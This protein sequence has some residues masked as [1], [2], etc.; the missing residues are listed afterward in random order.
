MDVLP[1]RPLTAAPAGDAP[2][3]AGP[4]LPAPVPPA[5][6]TGYELPVAGMGCPRCGWILALPSGGRWATC[7]RC[8]YTASPPT[9]RARHSRLRGSATTLGPVGRLLL[10]VVVIGPTC[11]MVW[12]L[13]PWGLL[14]SVSWLFI[15]TP[16]L[17]KHIWAKGRVS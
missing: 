13:G 3:A 2:S 15:W 8:R 5:A 10:T 17:L 6:A 12:A 14:G 9:P 4:E 16:Y 7:T 1:G 11:L